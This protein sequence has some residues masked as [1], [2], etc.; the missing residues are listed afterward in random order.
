[1]TAKPTLE[2]YD[3]SSSPQAVFSAPLTEVFRVKT[4]SSEKLE[5][6][7]EGWIEFL[8][9]IKSLVSVSKEPERNL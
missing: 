2:A 3:T 8:A 1:V 4:P 5:A 7:E 6:A 9:A